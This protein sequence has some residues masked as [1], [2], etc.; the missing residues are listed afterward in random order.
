[1]KVAAIDVGTNTALLLV[2]AVDD[3]GVITPIL[4]E[5]R[6]P[7]LGKGVDARGVLQP[8]SI[9][10]ALDVLEE[11]LRLLAPHEPE[12]LILAATSA[13]RDA[14][15]KDEFREIV[16]SRTGL[17]LEVLDGEAE[18]LWTYRGA[19]SGI[20]GDGLM[21]VVDIGGGSTE[22]TIGDG[23]AIRK[24]MSLDLGS[25]RLTERFFRNDPPLPR[26]IDEARSFVREALGG[27]RTF[28]APE[29]IGVAGTAAALALLDQGL[30]DFRW[31]AVSDYRLGIE[32]IDSLLRQ[33]QTM[34]SSQIRNLNTFLEGRED[35]IIAGTLIL[36][37]LLTACGFRDVVVSDR[38][39]RYG[40]VL[41]EWE[42]RAKTR[43]VPG[44][45]FGR[46]L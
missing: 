7:R 25:V 34:P 15:N 22:I 37:E 28:T 42:R 14:A 23:E 29:L 12:A 2:A 43:S 11:Y 20:P 21:T 24:S 13:V 46:P 36:A 38:G 16:H 40:L 30:R 41:R 10:R 4:D 32:R 31:E 19:R 9:R 45:D 39:V 27:C 18:A 17:D 35:I 5:Q 3:H 26:E 33:I 44:R 1:M 8:D 6:I